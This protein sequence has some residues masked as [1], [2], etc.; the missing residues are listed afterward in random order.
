MIE[1]AETIRTLDNVPLEFPLAG[2]ASRGLAFAIDT[3]IVSFASVF[4]FIAVMGA[5]SGAGLGLGWIWGLGLLGAFLIQWGYFVFFE[6]RM[7]GSTP[8]KNVLKLRVITSEGGTPSPGAL[9]I[10]NLLRLIPDTF[11]GVILMAIDPMARR[12]GDR[13]AGTL[14]IHEAPDRPSLALGTIP[15]GWGGDQVATVE[16]YL[17]RAAVLQP[18]ISVEI[19]ERIL[20][21][22]MRDHPEM[23][24]GIDREGKHPATVLHE[25][26]RVERL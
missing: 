21:W 7:R 16:A 15:H 22:L 19:G 23:L 14:V 18:A 4:W 1:S 17:E 10:R 13:L 8:G 3:L 6:I 9:V 26:F 12:A 2:V 5:G 25:V 24:D 11:V 20:R